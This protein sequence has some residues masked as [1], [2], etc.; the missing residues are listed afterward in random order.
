VTVPI[1]TKWLDWLPTTIA[2]LIAVPIAAYLWTLPLQLQ[3]FGVISPY[4]IPINMVTAP[5]V[6]V[7]SI[8]GIVS[9]LAALIYPLAGSIL[10]GLLYYP[11]HF[12]IQVVEFGNQ[13]PGN[14]FAVGTLS[15]GQ[16][17]AIYGLFGLVWWHSYWQR[18]WR[19]A[20]VLGIS[21]V[22]IPAWYNHT[23]LSQVTVLATA[24]KPMLVVQDRGQVTLV[25]SVSEEDAY[26]SV[27]PFLKQQGINSIDGAIATDSTASY[28]RGWYQILQNRPTEVLYGISSFEQSINQL[29]T[30]QSL[31][32][33]KHLALPDNRSVTVNSIA[34][35]LI[36]NT[37]L[38]LQLQ[39]ENQS[40]LL[41][42]NLQAIDQQRLIQAKLLPTA[43]VLW[44]SGQNLATQLLEMIKPNVAI[45]AS[46]LPETAT[47]LQQQAIETYSIDRDGAVQ[48]TAQQG[49][50]S[51][52]L[53][54]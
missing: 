19:I 30:F 26:F 11:T 1:L 6:T 49:F 44:W 42:G 35:R 54:P 10:A 50:T 2:P 23:H 28:L 5:L 25:N 48:W 41:L 39:I 24:G 14:Q 4:S 21:L 38:V 34:V 31:Q 40:W 22:A 20:V 3:A 43:Q 46:I 12:L 13:L 36:S 15:L 47:Q 45:A 37:P 51:V 53:S 29:L 18:S 27:L 17:A 7:A 16:V 8:G 33:H 9:A 52:K 32:I